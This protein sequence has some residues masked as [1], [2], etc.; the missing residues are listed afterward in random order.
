MQGDNNNALM[1][2]T[3]YG[4]IEVVKL[5]VRANANPDYKHNVSN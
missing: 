2:A 3:I 5:L 1:F 4:H